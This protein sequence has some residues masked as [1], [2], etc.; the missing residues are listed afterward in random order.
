MWC[1]HI[2]QWLI[3]NIPPL[4][5]IPV[6]KRKWVKTW[7]P[8]LSVNPGPACLGYQ[9]DYLPPGLPFL[10][11]SSTAFGFQ[12]S[13]IV[14][15]LTSFAYGVP[16]FW[17]NFFLPFSPIF[18]SS[19]LTPIHSSSSSLTRPFCTLTPSL[20]LYLDYNPIA[21]FSPTLLKIYLVQQIH[22]DYI[23]CLNFKSWCWK[24]F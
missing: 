9:Q 1:D 14:L 13:R 18:L 23:Q 8:R 16:S 17:N 6:W 5:V 19:W 4:W 21:A 11:P 12:A 10:L 20:W 2:I 7:P 22:S 24:Y 15:G 3:V